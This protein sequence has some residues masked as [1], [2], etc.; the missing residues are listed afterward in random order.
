MSLEKFREENTKFYTQV[1]TTVVYGTILIS[2]GMISL[3]LKN[4]F[5]TDK[6]ELLVFFV[7]FILLIVLSIVSVSL[8]FTIRKEINFIKDEP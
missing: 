8:Y 7:G 6:K 3:F 5:G 2:G 1:F 4:D